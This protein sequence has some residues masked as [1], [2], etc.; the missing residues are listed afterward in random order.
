MFIYIKSHFTKFLFRFCQLNFLFLCSLS[1]PHF[2]FMD[3]SYIKILYFTISQRKIIVRKCTFL[4]TFRWLKRNNQHSHKNGSADCLKYSSN[5]IIY[6][7]VIALVSCKGFLCSYDW[8]IC[9]VIKNALFSCLFDFF[10]IHLAF[11]I[12]F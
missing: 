3:K 12:K 6:I 1:T 8:F 5:Q 2:Y 4:C 11:L 10:I 9:S 7:A